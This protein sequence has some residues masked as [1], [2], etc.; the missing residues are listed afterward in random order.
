VQKLLSLRIGVFD[1]S[2]FKIK[3]KGGEIAFRDVFEIYALLSLTQPFNV[4]IVKGILA[5][6]IGHELKV[7]LDHSEIDEFGF[8]EIRVG[9][10]Q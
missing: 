7:E 10:L 2:G 9:R 6:K 3:R 8:E 1:V 4:V 5:N